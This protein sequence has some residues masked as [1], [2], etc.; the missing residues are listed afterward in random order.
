MLDG[1][2]QKGKMKHKELSYIKLGSTCETLS[3]QWGEVIGFE[4][5]KK[6]GLRAILFFDD[7]TKK[8]IPIKDLKYISDD[9]FY[10]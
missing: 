9:K 3:G 8:K 4:K 7:Y 10:V 5:W 6:G 1:Q 2:S